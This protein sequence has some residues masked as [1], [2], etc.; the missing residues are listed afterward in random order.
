MPEDETTFL[1]G[2]DG[3]FSE[4]WRDSLPESIRESVAFEGIDNF[5]SLATGFETLKS[6]P[7]PEVPKSLMDKDGNLAEDWMEQVL[8]DELKDNASLKQFTSLPAI[9]KTIVNQNKIVGRKEFDWSKASD[10][11]KAAVRTSQGVPEDD[12]GYAFTAPDN[13]PEYLEYN[14]TKDSAFAA[15]AH[16]LGLSVEQAQGLHSWY[17][18]GQIVDGTKNYEE[19]KAAYDAAEAELRSELGAA[20]EQKIDLANRVVNTMELGEELETLG[21]K[22]NPATIKAMLKIAGFISEDRLVGDPKVGGGN[23]MMTP[24]E[25]QDEV[26]KMMGEENSPLMDRDH[27]EHAAYVKRKTELFSMIYK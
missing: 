19:G 24:T 8:G 4:G 14:D 22:S 11:E 2:P 20:Y 18:D 5:E 25:A 17:N 27:P 3:N 6:A 10:E 21:L 12:K 26:N 23:Q 7:V 15:K 1:V 9:A 16:E 13:I